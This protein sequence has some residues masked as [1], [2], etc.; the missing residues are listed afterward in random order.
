MSIDAANNNLKVVFIN[1]SGQAATRVP[2]AVSQHPGQDLY[3]FVETWLD[4]RT[5]LEIADVDGYDA[6]H[7]TR[8]RQHMGRPSGGVTILLRKASHIMGTGFWR[9]RGDPLA[10]ILWLESVLHKLSFAICYFS[11][12]SSRLYLSGVL[13]TQPLNTLLHGLASANR[14]GHQ[15]IVLGDF[16]TRVGTSDGDVVP[17]LE[18]AAMPPQLQQD[19]QHFIHIYDCIPV[20]RQNCDVHIPDRE[21]AR[22]FM[23]GLNSVQCVLLNGRVAG[24][25][26]GQRTFFRTAGQMKGSSTIDFAIVS[27]SL[28][29]RVQR[30]TIYDQDR[31]LSHDHCAMLL[32]LSFQHPSQASHGRESSNRKRVVYRPVGPANIKLY[33]EA[34]Q[35][36]RL[37]FQ[38]VLLGMQQQSLSIEQGLQRLSDAVITCAKHM[39][40]RG[41]AYKPSRP[42]PGAPWFDDECSACNA[43]FKLAWSAHLT[44]PH[45]QHLHAIAVDARKTYRKLLARKKYAF[46]QQLQ[47]K[48]LQTYFSEQQGQFWKAFLGK[49]DSACP[50]S[51]VMEW[52]D[53]FCDIMGSPVDEALHADPAHADVASALHM[54]HIV[55]RDSMVSLNEPFTMDEVVQVL[56]ALPRGKSA[57]LQGMTCE[58]LRLAVVRVP[59]AAV[60]SPGT[61]YV[62]EPLAACLT[63]IFQNLSACGS[64]PAVMQVSKLTP[65][66]KSGQASARLDKN[67]YRGISVASIFSKVVDKLLH[68]RLDGKLEQLGLRAKTQCGFRKG[69]GTLDALFTLSHTINM[70]RHNKKRLYVVF[71]DFK[72]AFDTVRRDVMIAR[73]KQL[74]VHGQFL[75]TLVLLY[76][77]VQQQV[78]IGGEMGRLFETYVGT[79]QGSELSPLLFGMFIDMLHE[80]I[81]MQVPGA[82]PLLEHMRVPDISYADDVTLIAYDDHAQAQRLLDC[83]SIFCAIFQ[84][85]VNQH[86]LKTCAVVFRCPNSRIPSDVVLTYRG[87]VV[88][89]KECYQCLGV[90]LHATKKMHVAAT[91]LAASGSRAMHAVL[92]RCRQQNI[93]QFDFKCRIFDVLVEPIMSYACQV[94]GPDVFVSKVASGDLYSAWSDAEKVHIS[95]LRTMAG[96]GD[97]CIEVLMR[98]FNRRPIMHHWVLLAARWFTTLKCMSGD[99]L[100][101]CAWVADIDLMLAGCCMCWTYQLLDT[102]SS[103]GV[104][105]RTAWDHRVNSVIDRQCIMHL[106]L[107]PKAIKLALHGKMASRWVAMLGDPRV[108]PSK[109]IEMCT[110]AAWVLKFQEGVDCT[111]PKHLKLCASFVVLQCLARLRLGWHQLRVRS[112]RIKKATARLPRDQRLCRLCSTEGAGFYAQRV[113][114]GCV[115]DVRHFLL[116]CPAYQHLRAKYSCVF[117]NTIAGSTAQND[118]QS[119]LMSIF[120]CD[121]QDQLAHVVYT[122]TVFRNHCLSLPYGSH[123]VVNH[124]QQIVEED[125]ELIRI[126]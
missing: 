104:L 83:L 41:N 14:K 107:V 46:K 97:C 17:N 49:R 50:I 118:V 38:N 119:R 34:L 33:C 102:M 123:I 72:K 122:M 57:D 73:C 113:G 15:C 92:G 23:H 52:T 32:E 95:Y 89:F 108:A 117:G 90:V 51:D 1:I 21:A 67:M 20:H 98:D 109:G 4:E 53:W 6:H 36:N 76:D 110:H 100:A 74:G 101:H 24:D 85:E 111:V 115:E 63:H 43:A 99:R 47:I 93:T 87:D 30:L 28:Y 112:D 126:Q 35:D 75:D 103:L 5:C 70:A 59:T 78:C 60:D 88:P 18:A 68:R 8:Q 58:L 48:H 94:W 116:E 62:C 7:S 44:S 86:E 120:D 66:P 77:K 25:E 40:R 3:C 16:N 31:N 69:H 9:M 81:Q 80:L 22:H 37:L 61:E 29:C 12:T 79:K 39:P 13:D 19:A 64:L 121:Q 105:S 114:V 27:A 26:L 96:V 45:D 106:Q 55:S 10:G 11:P 84:M 56:Q 82:G 42:G 125:V 65:V 91:A 54:R 71:V 2:A 124:A